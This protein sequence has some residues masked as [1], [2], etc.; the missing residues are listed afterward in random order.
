MSIWNRTRAFWLRH[1]VVTGVLLLPWAA[2]PMLRA[3]GSGPTPSESGAAAEYLHI[4]FPVD[5][6]LRL[7]DTDWGRS[8]IVQRGSAATAELHLVLRLENRASQAIHGIT[9]LFVTQD[10]APGGKASITLPGLRLAPGETFPAKVDLRLLQPIAAGGQ[11][12][13]SVR[14]DG[15]LFADLS[16]RGENTLNSRRLLSALEL[17]IQQ[18]RRHA[19]DLLRA[20]GRDALAREMREILARREQSPRVDLQWARRGRTTALPASEPVRF[21][22]L[23]VPDSP[24]RPVEGTIRIAANEAVEP[25]IRVQNRSGREIRYAEIGWIIRD[26]EGREFYAGTLP[27]SPADFELKPSG[28]TL[29]KQDGVLR[30][31]ERRSVNGRMQDVPVRLGEMVGYV[32][33]VQFADGSIWMPNRYQ[34]STPS[35]IRSLRLSPEQQR[36]ASLYAR[37]GLDAV[38]KDL[39]E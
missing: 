11:P 29:V 19:R 13:V 16:F 23:H 4:E 14:L 3:Q 20:N 18:D 5:S 36:L 39:Q 12:R 9:L 31:S 6:P 37:E 7:V 30:F 38:V 17:E 26:L 8:R 15:V 24:L 27:A 32:S 22:F 33:Q 21:A 10:F 34:A 28:E 35:A 1:L 25:S 2:T